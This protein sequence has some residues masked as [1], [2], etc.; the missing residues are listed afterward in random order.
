ME[1]N[2]LLKEKTEQGFDSLFPITKIQNVIGLQ[3]QLAKGGLY[4]GILTEA[5]MAALELSGETKKGHLCYCEGTLSFHYVK[6][7]AGGFDEIL[8]SNFYG[9]YDTSAEV[10]ALVG[11][12]QLGDMVFCKETKGFWAFDGVGFVNTVPF[13]NDA[14]IVISEIEPVPALIGDLWMQIIA[15]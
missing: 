12:Y 13:I 15:E 14:K 2:I 4:L 5:E 3:E 9:S 7:N 10:E 8:R 1:K 11:A 6:I